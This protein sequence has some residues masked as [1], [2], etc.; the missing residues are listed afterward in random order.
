MS[1]K[2]NLTAVIKN[3]TDISKIESETNISSIKLYKKRWVILF[4]FSVYSGSNAF[5]WIQYSIIS[6]II[7]R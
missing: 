6:N 1:E 5:Q 4:L 7:T 3:P 2:E